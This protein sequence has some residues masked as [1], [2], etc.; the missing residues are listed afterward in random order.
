MEA[1]IHDALQLMECDRVMVS[2][3][4]LKVRHQKSEE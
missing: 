2:L 4:G 3:L 1:K